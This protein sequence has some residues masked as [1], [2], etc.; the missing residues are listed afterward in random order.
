LPA[1]QG[2]VATG[3]LTLRGMEQPVSLPF[4]LDL[5]GDTAVMTGTTTLDRRDFGI[6]KSYGD[7]ASVGFPV[8]VTVDL[9][10]RRT[11]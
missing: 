11:P 8:T 1:D 5:Q 6:G 2:Y 4:S 3:T 10:A 9:V 7:E